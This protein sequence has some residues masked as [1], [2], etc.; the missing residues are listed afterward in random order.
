MEKVKRQNVIQSISSYGGSVK[1]ED[2]HWTNSTHFGHVFVSSGTFFLLAHPKQLS[3]LTISE[4]I[5][6]SKLKLQ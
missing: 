4:E 6:F 2:G 5:L 3:S 1:I